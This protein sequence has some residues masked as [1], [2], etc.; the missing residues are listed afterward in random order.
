MTP[1]ACESALRAGL[2]PRAL[3]LALRLNSQKLLRRCVEG[4]PPPAVAAVAS[5]VPA[6]YLPR[7]LSALAD[8]LD[9]SPHLEHLLS[10]LRAVFAAH[11]RA[12][13]DRAGGGVA[14]GDAGPAMTQLVKALARIHGDLGATAGTNLY[15]LARALFGVRGVRGGAHTCGFCAWMG[16]CALT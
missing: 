9:Q 13:Q 2:Y 3:L 7:T 8:L 11:G 10:W 16:D 14:G 1:E 5:A 4:T 12:L 15:T 6:A